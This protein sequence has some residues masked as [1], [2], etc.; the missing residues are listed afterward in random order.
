MEAAVGAATG[1]ALDSEEALA[2]DL[3]RFTE[4]DKS[5]GWPLAEVVARRV[6]RDRG[7]GQTRGQ[8]DR[9]WFDR[10]IYHRMS[11]R[12]FATA[13]GTAHKRV[14]CYLEAW[15]RAA[16]VKLV[17]PVTELRPGKEIKLPDET[18]HP[19]SDYYHSWET[20]PLSK[21]RKAAIR[22]EA[23]RNGVSATAACRISENPKALLT[24]VLAD[25]STRETVKKA[26]SEH[27]RRQSVADEHDRTAAEAA[28]EQAVALDV[29][30]KDA[31]EPAAEQDS[32]QAE[33]EIAMQVFDGMT[34]VRRAS[35]NILS[36]LEKRPVDFGVQHAGEIANLCDAAIATLGAI[37]DL[38]ASGT[39]SLSDEALRAFMDESGNV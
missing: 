5:Q 13:T 29:T 27:E 39:G 30:Q 11:A 19:F 17:P 31:I 35:L 16:E 6:E 20:R 2:A 15:E 24:A 10:T 33:T 38:A 9:K 25:K 21:H 12:D 14:L 3:A 37:R 18:A 1:Q 32:A 34:T 22:E 7:R 23:E 8:Q 36:L 26:I 4:H 28:A